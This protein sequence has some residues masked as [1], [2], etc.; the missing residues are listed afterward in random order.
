MN[1]E[2]AGTIRC[3]VEDAEGNIVKDTGEF[4][5]LIL[6]QG[7]DHIG[8][9][10]SFQM[11]FYCVLGTGNSEP[12][13]TQTGLDSY[14]GMAQGSHPYPTKT[15]VGDN[16]V[17][18]RTSSYTFQPFGVDKNISEIGL[19]VPNG[20]STIITTRALIKNIEGVNTSISLLGDERLTVYYTLYQ[21]VSLLDFTDTVNTKNKAGE[22]VEYTY[23]VRPAL[24]TTADA[25]REGFIGYSLSFGA[26]YTYGG[27]FVSTL[28]IVDKYNYQTGGLIY[29]DTKSPTYSEY[30]VGSYT[31]T[32]VFDFGYSEAVGNIRSFFLPTTL[33][34]FQ[35]RIG[36]T[37]GDN[38]LVKTGQDKMT[39]P[40]VFSWGR[41]EGEL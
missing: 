30:L 31:K 38:P 26:G 23:T 9:A 27:F 20:D 37:V 13:V 19:G 41:Y 32:M 17:I 5:N 11:G 3:V 24:V 18:K 15:E 28:D 25:Y 36:T 1:V 12:L 6:N 22:L 34:L 8:I 7:L 10:K 2:I 33:G 16:L 4:R 39:L 14:L 21:I 35:I 40:F 29:S